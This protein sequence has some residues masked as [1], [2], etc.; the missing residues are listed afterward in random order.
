[1][2]NPSE[3]K[4]GE[5][6][7]AEDMKDP[8]VA[9]EPARTAI[10]NQLVILDGRL[11]SLHS[12]MRNGQLRVKTSARKRI[13]CR[14][15]VR[16]APGRYDLAARMRSAAFSAI[17]ITGAFVLPLGSAGITE[18]STTRSPDTPRT[19]NSGSV[20]DVESEPIAQVPSTC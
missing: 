10:A 4:S 2:I 14:S 3:S 9:A 13:L 6:L 8:D 12:G 1:M 19:L 7:L 5:E 17:M 11:T 20:T 18:V 16:S 15:R